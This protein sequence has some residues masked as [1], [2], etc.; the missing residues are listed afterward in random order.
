MGTHSLSTKNW[1]WVV[2]QKRYVCTYVLKQFN[3]PMQAPT[4]GL[5]HRH[6]ARTY[7]Q[8]NEASAAV[9]KAVLAVSMPR[10][11]SVHRLQYVNIVLLEKNAVG[12]ATISM[13]DLCCGT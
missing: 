7:F 3:Y 6:F 4:Q 11:G 13:C 10:L 1:G 8:T 9:V 5:P 2:A 12:K